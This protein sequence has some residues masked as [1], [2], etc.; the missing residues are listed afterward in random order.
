MDLGG[1]DGETTDFAGMGRVKRKIRALKARRR[2]RSI[3]DRPLLEWVT[4][5]SPDLEAPAHLGPI[6]A[7]LDRAVD[8]R[9][10]MCFSVP[11]GHWKSVTLHHWCARMLAL[12]PSLRI[13][14]GTYDRTFAD[15]NVASIRAL[16]DRAQVAIGNVDRAGVFTTRARG[17]V[18]GFGLQKPPT[19]RR[20]DIIIVDDPYASRA[21]AESATIRGKVQRGFTADLMTRQVAGGSTV[22]VVHTRW[23]PDDL[24]GELA[25]SGWQYVNIPAEDAEGRP[26]LPQFWTREMLDKQRA[27]SE[28]DWWSLFMGQ[29]RP[30]GGTIFLDAPALVESFPADGAWVYVVGVDLAR[31]EKQKNDANAY[32]LTRRPAAERT[33][34]PTIDLMEWLEESGPIADV[35][36]YD[37][38]TGKPVHRPGFVRHLVRLRTLYPGAVFVMYVGRTET[39][40]LDLIAALSA[41]VKIVPMEAQ[42]TKLWARAEAGYAPAWNAGRVRVSRRHPK[43]GDLV[44]L[45]KNFVGGAGVDHAISAITS[46]YDWHVTHGGPPPTR[47]SRTTGQGSEATRYGVDLV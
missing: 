39:N 44:T 31:G 24:I 7:E 21:E 17:R 34:T 8:A 12:N 1:I 37:E 9:V 40:M 33:L 6:V 41:G 5:L 11:P 19:G 22:I 3:A 30:P 46:A 42:G 29:P 27:A 25:R 47:G 16:C 23:H 45:H 14:Y 26:L 13:G 35:D 10:Q 32:A 18:M 4:L 2:V 38:R 43:T 20:F 36:Q 15:E 28:Y